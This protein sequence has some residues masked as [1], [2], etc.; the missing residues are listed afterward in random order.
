M[1]ELLKGAYRGLRDWVQG[2]ESQERLRELV[3][4]GLAYQVSQRTRIASLHDVEFRVYSQF[5]DDG[6]VQ[7]LVSRLPQLPRCFVEFGVEDYSEATTRFLMVNNHWS[8][9]VIDGSEANI[10]RLRRQP[11]FW[12]YNLTAIASFLTLDNLEEVVGRWGQER[13]VGLLHIDVDGNDY[14]FWEGLSSISPGLVIMEYNALFGA[15][16][17]ITVPYRADFRR[18][19]MHHSGQ[20]FG[21]SLAALTHLAAKKGYALLGTNSAGNNAYFVL[22]EFLGDSL[23]EVTPIQAWARPGFRDSR[24]G[25]GHLDFR[26]FEA[27]QSAI[28]GLPV[29]N[30]ITGSSESF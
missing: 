29:V 23:R 25:R 20:F 18:F 27:R 11:W 16:R 19:R 6:I 12:R 9:L 4:G 13:Q 30:V 17:A 5:G 15:E 28:R 21:A 10:A 14:W 2:R 7:W 1:R 8:G 3:G 24:D 22:R 26:S